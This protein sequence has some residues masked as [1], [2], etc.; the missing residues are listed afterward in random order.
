LG[1]SLPITAVRQARPR[2]QQ[3]LLWQAGERPNQLLPLLLLL[4]LLLLS[5]L[6]LPL[7]GRSSH[8]TWY[9]CTSV[10]GLEL[11]GLTCNPLCARCP[12]LQVGV[13]EQCGGQSSSCGKNGPD[14]GV[15]CPEVGRLAVCAAGAAS[16]AACSKQ[17]VLLGTMH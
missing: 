17:D 12:L 8:V 1:S 3:R 13:W 4:S 9:G 14:Q 16:M 11:P 7:K 15:C 6:G 10:T 5:L 2:P